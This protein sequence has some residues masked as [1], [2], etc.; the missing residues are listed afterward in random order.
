MRSLDGYKSDR[1]GFLNQVD[2]QAKRVLSQYI[3]SQHCKIQH[4]YKY[5]TNIET[6]NYIVY[7]Y[8]QGMGMEGQV[9]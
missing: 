1:N 2:T 3:Y 4:E 6:R 9:Q 8:K 5:I 7:C